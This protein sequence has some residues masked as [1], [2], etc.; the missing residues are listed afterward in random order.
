MVLF[1]TVCFRSESSF[2]IIAV[3][4]AKLSFALQWHTLLG[5]DEIPGK[6]LYE[7]SLMKISR[8]VPHAVFHRF[9]VV[10]LLL[11]C[12]VIFFQPSANQ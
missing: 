12:P 9:F 10:S 11:L 1:A 7:M 5:S 3:V 6:S 4:Q 2:S 8:N